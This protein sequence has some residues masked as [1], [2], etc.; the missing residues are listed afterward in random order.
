M[1]T[2]ITMAPRH[3]TV[4]AIIYVCTLA[5]RVHWKKYGVLG[6]RVPLKRD[7]GVAGRWRGG[8]QLDRTGKER[9][10]VTANGE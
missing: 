1:I 8:G 5:Y 2:M 4:H 9:K 7:L 3:C 10:E 6:R